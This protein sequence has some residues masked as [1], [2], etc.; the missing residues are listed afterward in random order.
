MKRITNKEEYLKSIAEKK[1]DKPKIISAKDKILALIKIG[2]Y[3]E[4]LEA[5]DLLKDIETKHHKIAFIF[6][7]YFEEQDDHDRAIEMIDYALITKSKSQQY[8]EFKDKLE[9][10][11]DDDILNDKNEQ[12][13]IVDEELRKI[14]EDSD[15]FNYDYNDFYKANSGNPEIL[16]RFATFKCNLKHGT[17]EKRIKVLNRVTKYFLTKAKDLIKA[18]EINNIAL[19]EFEDDSNALRFRETIAIR[20]EHIRRREENKARIREQFLQPDNKSDPLWNMTFDYEDSDEFKKYKSQYYEYERN[21]RKK[22]SFKH[23]NFFI[24]DSEFNNEYSLDYENENDIA[25]IEMIKSK[26]SEDLFL[27]NIEIRNILIGHFLKLEYKLR[28]IAHKNDV[29]FGRGAENYEKTT[30]LYDFITS[31]DVSKIEVA[32]ALFD[33]LITIRKMNP[34][35]EIFAKKNFPRLIS[36]L[37][38]TTRWTRNYLVHSNRSVFTLGRKGFLGKDQNRF[39][40]IFNMKDLDIFKAISTND[41]KAFPLIILLIVIS[42]NEKLT[43]SIISDIDYKLYNFFSSLKIGSKKDFYNSLGLNENWSSD[44]IAL[45]SKANNEIK[46]SDGNESDS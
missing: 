17:E 21:A 30:I 32:A 4:A 14:I 38:S 46:D 24:K 10:P 23:V 20:E 7:K 41:K 26:I 25:T 27:L 22:E 9:N 43:Q 19:E 37:V 5:F 42:N 28:N 36:M 44:V 31:D 40:D 1:A 3:S 39:F 45:I 11:K 12:P 29:E 8:L 15:S 2:K 13:K 6:A 34:D 33:R 16:Y 35:N 18:K